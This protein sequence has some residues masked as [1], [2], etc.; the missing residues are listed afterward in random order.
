MIRSLKWLPLV[1]LLVILVACQSTPAT[2]E[3]PPEAATSEQALVETP[4]EVV[5][6]AATPGETPT[7]AVAP[8]STPVAAD[9]VE[10]EAGSGIRELVI[11]YTN[12][13]H[14][15]IEA[16]DEGG[17]AAGLA[18]LWRDQ[19]GYVPDGNTLILSGGDTWTGP[20]CS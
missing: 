4:T 13:E 17:G 6:P 15:W 3:R 7:V 16:T 1:L 19:E 12:D 18:G 5:A 11:L 14:G 10:D 8:T 9:G 2:V 20:S